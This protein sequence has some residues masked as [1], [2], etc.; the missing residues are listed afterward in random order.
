VSLVY[1]IRGA[2]LAIKHQT[3]NDEVRV[4]DAQDATGCRD[5]CRPAASL[6]P[7][8]DRQPGRSISNRVNGFRISAGTNSY[9]VASLSHG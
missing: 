3:F 6:C 4:V 9:R 2:I 1:G 8:A 7:E 5:E